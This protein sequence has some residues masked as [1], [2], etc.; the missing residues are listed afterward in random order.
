LT[1]DAA[2][3]DFALARADGG[4]LRFADANGRRYLPH[5]VERY[6]AEAQRAV[7][8][9]KVQSC[10]RMA[11][12]N[13]PTWAIHWPEDL[14]SGGRTFEMFDDFGRAGLGYY[15]FG[16][17]TTVLTRSEDWESEAPHT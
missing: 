7:V 15:A 12:H 17:P 5:W 13:L 9:V 6:E 11:A 4:D 10:R 1:L 2:N 3:F 14:S 8:W 16:P